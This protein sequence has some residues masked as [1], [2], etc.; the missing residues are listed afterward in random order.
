MILSP[1]SSFA[2]TMSFQAPDFVKNTTNKFNEE[3]PN[4]SK[5]IVGFSSH[6][7]QS[8]IAFSIIFFAFSIF[9]MG[10]L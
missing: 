4:S 7:L 6:N 10:V 1:I 8:V 9:A 5:A 2:K 3:S